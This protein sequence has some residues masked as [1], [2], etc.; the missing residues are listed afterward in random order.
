MIDFDE[1]RVNERSFDGYTIRRTDPFGFW[2]VQ[3]SKGREALKGVFTNPQD[4]A[5]AVSN[6][7]DNLKKK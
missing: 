7:L 4:A 1:T 2:V 3:T 6:H 5:K